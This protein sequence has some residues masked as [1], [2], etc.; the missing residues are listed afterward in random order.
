[1][2]DR[3]LL[4]PYFLDQPSD[5]LRALVAH[6][7]RVVTRP[8]PPGEPL[9]RMGLLY[10]ALAGEVA[11]ALAAGQRPVAMLGDCCATIGVLAGLQRAGQQPA[12]VWLDAHGD[13]NTY[14]TTPSGFLG[15]MPLAMAVGLG[16]DTLL[17]ATGLRPWPADKVLLADGRDLDPGERDNLAALAIRRVPDLEQLLS[18]AALPGGPLYVHFDVD[19]IDP[20]D[21]AAMNYPAPGGPSAQTVSDVL[22]ALAA[23][24]RIVAISVSLWEPSL[25][26]DGHTQAVVQAAL[27][28]LLGR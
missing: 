16:D 11:A 5:D 2:T 18:P 27:N 19:V 12:L 10:D 3:T 20:A 22:R 23:T 9:A 7:A 1:M 6:D 4:S 26:P 28:A 13:F 24:G 15:G 25:D 21:A 14:D 8:L 17:R